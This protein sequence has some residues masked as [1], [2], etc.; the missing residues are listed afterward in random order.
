MVAQLFGPRPATVV[1]PPIIEPPVPTYVY[2]QRVAGYRLDE[3][4][5]TYVLSPEYGD[6]IGTVQRIVARYALG[7]DRRPELS[8]RYQYSERQIQA[9]VCGFAYEWFTRPV[10]ARLLALGIASETMRRDPVRERQA[11]VIAAYERL[12]TKA[13]EYMNWPHLYPYDVKQQ[14]ADDLYLLSGAWREEL[15]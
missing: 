15:S 11:Q 2:G 3:D 7:Y 14:V 5:K 12:A 1:L 6:L 10:R 9:I 4:R 13:S 8:R